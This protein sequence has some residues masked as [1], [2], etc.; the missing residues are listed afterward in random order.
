MSQK[1]GVITSNEVT[2]IIENKIKKD[3]PQ[4][5]KQKAKNINT[6]YLDDDLKKHFY[7]K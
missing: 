1:I 7:S 6:Y 3:I 5:I 4:I 2:T